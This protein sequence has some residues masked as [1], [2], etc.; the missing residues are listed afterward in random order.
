MHQLIE[1]YIAAIEK[2]LGRKLTVDEKQ[3]AIRCFNDGYSVETAFEQ[4]KMRYSLK[5]SPNDFESQ[6]DTLG[7]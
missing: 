2:L 7:M 6:S 4:I 5:S 1:D 3:F